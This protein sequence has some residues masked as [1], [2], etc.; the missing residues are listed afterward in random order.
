MNKDIWVHIEHVE[1]KIASVSLELLSE[2][3]RLQAQRPTPGKV[4]AVLIGSEVETLIP[5]LEEYGAEKIYVA[6]GEN[7]KLYQP[8]YYASIYEKLIK[9][10]DP[11]ILLVGSTALGSQL[12]PTIAL[13]VKTGVAA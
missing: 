13:K 10:N 9:E 1:G 3:H 5:T 2:A 7:L 8:Q 12:A 4:V 6:D 11:D